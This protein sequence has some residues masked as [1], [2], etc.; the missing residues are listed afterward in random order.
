MVETERRVLSRKGVEMSGGTKERMDEVLVDNLAL[1]QSPT[2]AAEGAGVSRRTVYRRME[3]PE[4]RQQVTQRRTM[5]LDEFTNRVTEVASAAM[6]R[7][8]LLMFDSESELVQ[9]RAART[10][11]DQVARVQDL[12]EL[13]SRSPK[14]EQ[15]CPNSDD[16]SE[17]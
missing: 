11:L 12:M 5:L 15:L 10:I 6:L 8:Q 2:D 16:R 3:D 17:G 7:V 1:G 4:F 13:E 9:L 14:V